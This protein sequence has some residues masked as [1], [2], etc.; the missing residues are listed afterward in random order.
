MKT[1]TQ[2][3]DYSF[4]SHPYKNYQNSLHSSQFVLIGLVISKNIKKTKY[5]IK[6]NTGPSRSW[7][8]NEIYNIKKFKTSGSCRS[9]FNII[10]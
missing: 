5:V 1:T 6:K 4:K 10:I 7:I 8:Y 9:I 2:S 3:F